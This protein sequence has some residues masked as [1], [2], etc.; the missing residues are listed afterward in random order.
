[1]VTVWRMLLPL[2]ALLPM[3]ATAQIQTQ[4][5]AAAA[6]S[7]IADLAKS[8]AETKHGRDGQQIR[9]G[10]VETWL[11]GVKERNPEEFERLNKLREED[12]EAFQKA[13]R[14]R[15]EKMREGGSKLHDEFVRRHPELA[16]QDQETR[17]LLEAYKT[18]SPDDKKQIRAELKKKLGETFEVREKARQEMIQHLESQLGQLKK[19]ADKRKANRDAIIER[20]VKELTENDPLAW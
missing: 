9:Q 15:L 11:K 1:M 13:L 20:R 2:C 18:A 16:K 8:K 7:K 14:E 19:D 3:V 4:T 12:P 10:A 5:T 6:E 17:K